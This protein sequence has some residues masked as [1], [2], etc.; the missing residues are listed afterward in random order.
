M[1][2]TSYISIFSISESHLRA[3]RIKMQPISPQ[4]HKPFFLLQIKTQVY[5][6]DPKTCI[7]VAKS[8]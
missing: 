7:K 1:N 8:S 3:T 5:Y 4:I 2:M 6:S